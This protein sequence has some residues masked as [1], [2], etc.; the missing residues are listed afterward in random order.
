[1]R[2][3]PRAIQQWSDS[4]GAGP[5]RMS[6]PVACRSVLPSPTTAAVSCNTAIASRAARSCITSVNRISRFL[7]RQSRKCATCT[8][9]ASI[10]PTRQAMD[11]IAANVRASNRRA[12]N[13][14]SSARSNSSQACR[15]APSR[16][17]PCSSRTASS[18][19]SSATSTAPGRMLAI[20]VRSTSSIPP[21][22]RS[23]APC[24][25]W[26]PRRHAAQSRLH[27]LHSRR[28]LRKLQRNEL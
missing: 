12:P 2:Q 25:T 27:T 22:N 6:Q 28:G 21:R 23:L 9:K 4:A 11:S 15:L 24:P 13:S 19:I 20:A 8:R 26:A 10:T 3:L 7:P 5:S 16:T 1:M 17:G 18:F 14:P